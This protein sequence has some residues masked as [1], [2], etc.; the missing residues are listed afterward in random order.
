MSAVANEGGSFTLSALNRDAKRE[1]SVWL[2]REESAFSLWLK[3]RC[4][5][6]GYIKATSSNA[7]PDRVRPEILSGVIAGVSRSGWDCRG[8]RCVLRLTVAPRTG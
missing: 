8:S 2:V 3:Q 1:M 5:T 6:D 7:T 4:L